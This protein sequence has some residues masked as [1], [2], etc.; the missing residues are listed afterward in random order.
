LGAIKPKSLNR[1]AK[2]GQGH[3][4]LREEN[5]S[6]INNCKKSLKESKIDTTNTPM[7]EHILSSLGTDTSIKNGGAKLVSWV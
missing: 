4:Y 6:F 5:L 7:H 2:I 3:L 1:I